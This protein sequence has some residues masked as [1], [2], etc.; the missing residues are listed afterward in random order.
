MHVSLIIPA[1]GHSERVPNKNLRKIGDK[2]LVQIACEKAL[3]CKAV[4]KVYLDTES[5]KIVNEVAELLGDGLEIIDRPKELATND[6]GANDM[7]IYGLH[8]I[9]ETDLLCQ[10]F[11]TSPLI[12]SE[13]IDFCIEKFLAGQEHDSFFTVTKVQEYF[14]DENNQPENFQPRNVPNSFELPIKYMETHGLYGIT[15][16]A[17]LMGKTRVGKS[18]MLI[19]IDTIEALDIN[20]ENDLKIARSLMNV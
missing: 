5:P 10:T 9:M 7:M 2:S 12:Q 6:I 18:P 17:L 1:K 20:T 4:S 3:N 14:W 11:A 8:S 15:P 13:T 19:E 16:A